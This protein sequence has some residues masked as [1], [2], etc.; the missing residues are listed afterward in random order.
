MSLKASGVM[1]WLLMPPV[2]GVEERVLLV[3]IGY[4]RFRSY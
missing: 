2:G 1:Y 4:D 3:M